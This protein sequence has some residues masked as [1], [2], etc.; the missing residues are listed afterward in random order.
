[1]KT[2]NLL[3]LPPTVVGFCCCCYLAETVSGQLL[4]QVGVTVIFSW[5]A[6]VIAASSCLSADVQNAIYLPKLDTNLLRAALDVLELTVFWRV[7]PTFWLRT[8]RW[9]YSHFCPRFGCELR[10]SD[11]GGLGISWTNA[12]HPSYIPFCGGRRVI[13]SKL[14]SGCWNLGYYLAVLFTSISG[15]ISTP[16]A[17][18]A[19]GEDI[20]G[21]GDRDKEI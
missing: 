19:R 11:A 10:H 1:L 14:Q 9:N 4:R 12:D 5:S 15:Q 20:R 13:C 18:G 16:L 2:V 8:C 3:V 21:Q 6:T 7:S 17:V